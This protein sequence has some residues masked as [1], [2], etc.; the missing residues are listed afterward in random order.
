MIKDQFELIENY[1]YMYHTGVYVILPTFPTTMQDSMLTTYAQTT[2]LGRS[3][4]I[5][6][7]SNSGP[8]SINFEFKLH[9]DLMLQINKK[10]ST[11]VTSVGEDYVDIM[12]KEI[13]SA[14]VPNYDASERMV[15]PPLVAVRIGNDV[16]I[17]GVI[18][19]AVSITYDLP[20]LRDGRYA[21]ISINFGVS[22]VTPYDAEIIRRMGSF[23]NGSMMYDRQIL[24]NMSSASRGSNITQKSKKSQLKKGYT[25]NTIY[26]LKG[27]WV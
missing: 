27:T 25:K 24:S 21:T 5:Y 10:N 4:P 1:I 7:F 26:T 14:A 20:M 15:D 9:R 11:V 13:Q 17:K 3:A 12:M 19:S 6:S 16:Y 23:R 22:E 18:S 8:R 2:L